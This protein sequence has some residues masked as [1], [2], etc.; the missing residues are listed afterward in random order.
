MSHLLTVS[1][2]ARLIGVT[3]SALQQR[4]KDGELRSFDGM[5]TADDLLL[6]Y[7]DTKF[8][9]DLLFEHLVHIKEESYAKRVR[10]RILPSKDVLAARLYAQSLELAD[11]RTH[12]QRYHSIIVRMQD[13]LQA[14]EQAMGGALPP[15]IPELESWLNRQLEEVL[16]TEPPNPLAVLD[17]Y[18]S[19]VTTHVELRPSGHEFFVEGADT[20]LEA[21][22]RSG[23]ALN[24]G[25]GNGN[26]GLC[27]ARIVSGQTKKVRHHDYVL[28]E[29]EKNMGFALMCSHAPVSDLVVEALEASGPSDIPYQEIMARVRFV[30]PLTDT[31]MLLHLQTPRTNRLRFLAGQSVTLSIGESDA[32]E[33]PV[34]SCPCDDRNLQFHIRNIPGNQFAQHV[35]G[36][37]R[38][39][40][41]IMVNG[42]S[43]AFVLRDDS[44]RP[45]LFIACDDGFAPIKSLVEHAMAVDMA[46]QMHLYWIATETDGH[47]MQNLCRSW[48]DAL[49][50]F[51]FSPLAADSVPEHGFGTTLQAIVNA[52]PE[53]LGRFDVYLAGPQAFVME[54]R[55][56]LLQCGMSEAHLVVAET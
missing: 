22:L 27:K 55:T 20:I 8:E 39:G 16:D 23:L 28:S 15:A 41:S 11:V 12:L 21:A 56:R 36:G 37:L 43:G 7:P 29:A 54:A 3:R 34:A 5:V 48:T 49:D 45:L 50:N 19:V 42:P 33:Y 6:A 44:R 51:E 9:E 13:R 2:A 17:D 30:Q 10:E 1:R 35:F 38:C 47:Y 52:H 40:D 32:A 53:G 24:Y 46:E 26:C 18:L 31:I 4:I 25:C 14:M